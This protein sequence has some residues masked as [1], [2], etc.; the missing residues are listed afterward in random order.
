MKDP[1]IRSLPDSIRTGSA[2]EVMLYRGIFDICDRSVGK[3][4]EL[5]CR[6]GRI[7]DNNINGEQGPSMKGCSK[8]DAKCLVPE[9]RRLNSLFRIRT[10]R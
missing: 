3:E 5:L 8:E 7:G 9:Q 4:R 2:D 1:V 10:E 6:F